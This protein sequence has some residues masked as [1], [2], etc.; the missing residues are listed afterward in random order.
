[1][2]F[3]ESKHGPG[4][5]GFVGGEIARYHS[6]TMCFTGLNVPAN[7]KLYSGVGYDV[8]YNRNAV[9]QY[10]LDSCGHC[11]QMHKGK[12]IPSCPKKYVTNNYQWVQLWDDD[13]VFSS[14]VLLRLLDTG[15]DVVVPFYVQRQPPFR[16]CIY[17]SE[18]EMGGFLIYNPVDIEGKT[19][20]LPIASAGAGGLLVRRKVLDT[21]PGPWFERQ[22]LI[23][24]DHMFFKKCRMQGF[25]P[26]CDLDVAI[27]H[28]TTVEVWPHHAENGRWGTRVDLKGDPQQIVEFW[29]KSYEGKP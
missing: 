16:P 9:I 15:A 21:I 27:G 10:A 19:G 7:S 1:M 25:Q 6:F 24:E 26:Y 14:D 17:K 29:D 20:L 2:I 22:G 28:S 3:V 5:V 11:G 12:D 4:V 8:S 13:H 18:H 23:G